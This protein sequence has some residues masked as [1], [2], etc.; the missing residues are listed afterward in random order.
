[1]AKSSRN[2]IFSSSGLHQFV[3]YD[4]REWMLLE[5]VDDGEQLSL[6]VSLDMWAQFSQT[7]AF[8]QFKTRH[9]ARDVDL[10]K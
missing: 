2:S 10:H 5:Q 9:P 1:M 4:V 3:A 7:Q 6:L 8:V